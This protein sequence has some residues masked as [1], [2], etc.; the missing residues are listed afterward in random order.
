MTS[1]AVTLDVSTLPRIVFGPKGLIWWGTTG[2]M[3]IETTAFVMLWITYFYLRGRVPDWPPGVLP[4]AMRWGTVQL[5]LLLVSFVPNYL[6]KLRAEKFD[7]QGVRLW[8]TMTTV[9]ALASIGVR[10]MEFTTLNVG[11]DTNAYGSIVWVLIGTHTLHLVT[12]FFDTLA[13]NVLAAIG[14]LERKRFI[15]FSDNAMYWNVIIFWWIVLY[16][17]IYLAPRYF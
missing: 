7:L 5:V 9:L 16:A 17:I 15:D 10:V 1:R 8:L 6:T 2:L 13:L 4:P 14:P 12:D 11:W 3:V